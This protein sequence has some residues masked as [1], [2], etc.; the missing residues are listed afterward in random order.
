[1][2]RRVEASVSAIQQAI[3]G[4]MGS[5]LGYTGEELEK[6]LLRLKALRQAWESAP[7]AKR[8]AIRA[9]HD[10]VRAEATRLQWNLIVQREAM[11]LT[12]HHDVYE[13]YPVPPRLN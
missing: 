13:F 3:R 7:E 5:R 2:G 11:G 9:Q 10:E 8:T 1:M 6:R 4:E 12:R